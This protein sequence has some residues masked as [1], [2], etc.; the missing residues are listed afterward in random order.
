MSP[1]VTAILSALTAAVLYAVNVPAS[2]ILM[3]NVPAALMAA[4]LSNFE[5]AATAIIAMLFFGETI[6]RRL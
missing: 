5:I 4:L 6:S 1:K 2:K 3:R